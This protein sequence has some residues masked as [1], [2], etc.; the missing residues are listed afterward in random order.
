M[1]AVDT[2]VFDVSPNLINLLNGTYDVVTGAL[3]PHRKNDYITRIAGVDYN[4]TAT[5][6]KWEKHLQL[7]IPDAATRL[8]FQVYMGHALIAGNPENAAIFAYGVG[9]NGKTVTFATIDAV[10]SKYAISA[11]P[12][13]FTE[14]MNDDAPRPDL[15]RMKGA[16]LITVP[17]GKQGRRLDE[18]VLKNLTGGSDDVTAR[19]LYGR[20]F[21]FKPTAKLCFHTNHLPKIT[22]RDNGIWRRIYPIP[23]T[24]VVPEE[25]RIKDYDKIMYTTEGDGILNW[26]IKGYKY[27]MIW[28]S[29]IYT[30]VID[31]A[32]VLYKDKEDV[33]GDFFEHYRITGDEKDK[34]PRSDLYDAYKV[35]CNYENSSEKPY[36]KNKFNDMIEE[37]VGSPKKSDGVWVWFGIKKPDYSF[38]K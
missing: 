11:S 19:F 5:C 6:D 35:W 32:R 24:T 2:D 9:K 23:F 7:V 22:G 38:N 28:G 33:L 4:P 18:G 10:L 30:T 17:E 21:S 34:V 16:R 12:A 3:S 1:V 20:E 26:L 36:T 27:Y 31:E 15:A 8:A 29:L 13:T 25:N 14:R 37:R